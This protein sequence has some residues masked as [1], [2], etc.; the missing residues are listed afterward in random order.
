MKR[1]LTLFVFG[2][3]CLLM[4]LA[5]AP[6]STPIPPA[7]TIA[8]ATSTLAPTA[9]PS[10]ATPIPPSATLVPPTNTVVPPTA[11]ATTIPPTA[12]AIPATNTVA[13]PTET[14]AP[15]TATK[16]APT[17]TVARPTNPPPPTQPPSG[18]PIDPGNAGI[19][20]VNNFD[21]LMTFTVLNTEYKIDPHT[22][23]L[24]QVP[25][26]QEFTASVSVQGVGKTNFGPVSVPAGECVR[27]APTAG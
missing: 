24:V 19:L 1:L 15:P 4:L 14:K 23:L 9:V 25:G 3:T 6:S 21:G 22:Q 5:C 27:Y 2:I 20:V 12:T 7:P 11:T 13:P 10:T 8:P 16:A 26:G 18:C 17:N